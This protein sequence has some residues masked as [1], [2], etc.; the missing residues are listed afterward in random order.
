MK[1]LIVDD[2]HLSQVALAATMSRFGA[3]TCESNGRDGLARFE[4]ALDA[5]EPFDLVFMD[6]QMPVMDGQTAL[7]AIR[8]LERARKVPPGQEAKAVMV[9]CFD[10]IKNVSAS[11]FRGQ[12][13]CYFTK[14][15]DMRRMV[16]ELRQEGLI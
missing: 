3:C 11:F 1:I 14:P 13:T 6:I 15:I 12:A 5:G 8:D 16:A 10:D 2:D 7:A 9:T 4:Q